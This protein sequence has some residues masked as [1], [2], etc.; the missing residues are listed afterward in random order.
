[1]IAGIFGIIFLYLMMA[2]GTFLTTHM[3]MRH[4]F[5]IRNEISIPVALIAGLLFPLTIALL[6]VGMPIAMIIWY[7]RNMI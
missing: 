3:L 5:D 4:F 6:F 7:V 2:S 1:M